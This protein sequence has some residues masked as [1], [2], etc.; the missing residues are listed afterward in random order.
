MAKDAR[1]YPVA[2]LHK[3]LE[4]ASEEFRRFHFQATVNLIGSVVLL[5]FLARFIVFISFTY[6]V[7]PL[8][9]RLRGPFIIDS[10][11][12]IAASAAVVWSLA[13]WWHQREFISRWG[14]RFEK[15]DVME[16]QLMPEE[17]NQP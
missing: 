3:F 7:G 17:Q 11:L 4:E 13:V 6:G 16:S 2:T 5:V 9:I 8:E 15:L 1:D 14:R 12:L 10:V